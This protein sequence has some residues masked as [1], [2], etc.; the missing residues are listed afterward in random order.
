VTN[1]TA[2]NEAERLAIL[3]SYGIL[4]TPIEKQFDDI[5]ELLSQLLDVPIAAVNLIAEGRQWFKAEVGLGTRE[6]PLDN[7]I[8]KFALLQE[9]QMVVP[10]TR[11]DP[12]FECN[13][14]VVGAPGLR[15]YAGQLL[16]TPA[17]VP[18]GTLCVLD[19]TPRPDGLTSR[20]QFILETLAQQVMTQ[21][22]LRKAIADQHHLLA[23]QQVIQVALKLERDQSQRLLEGM[24]EG[25]IYLDADFYVRQINKGGLELEKRTAA[26]IV[27]KSLWEAW[28]GTESLPMTQHYRHAMT[29]RVPANFE[30]HYVFPDGRSMWLDIRAHP[31]NDGLAIFYRDI[32]SRKKAEE[33]LRQTAAALQQADQRKNEF[34]AMLAHE[35]RNPLAPISSAAMVLSTR[36]ADEATVRR[37]SAVISRQAKH[38]T[39]LIDDL[40]DVSRV[41]QGKVELETAEIDAKDIIADA[42]EQVRPLIEKH[43]HQLFVQLAPS[44]ST[45][46]GDRKRLVQVITNLLGNAAKYT[47]DGGR[48]E[49]LLE[50]HTDM[51]GITVRDNGIGMSP[52]LIGSAFELFSQGKRG[53]DRSQGGLGIGLALVKSLVQLHHGSVTVQS[54]GLGKGSTFEVRIPRNSSMAAAAGLTETDNDKDHIDT[55][56]IAVV[57]DNEDAATTLALLLETFGHEVHTAFTAK[58]ALESLPSFRPDVC[59]LDIGL[60]EIDGFDLARA[61]RSVPAIAGAVLI[62]VTGYGQEKD[63]Q[64]ADAAGFDDLFTKPVDVLALNLALQ[65]VVRRRS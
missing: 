59:L 49:V 5:V 40:L 13:P 57:D 29:T 22:E 9:R 8:C 30:E 62:A 36:R 65:K 24:D 51:I 48:I 43:R 33:V 19:V 63:R 20:E 10:D 37:V 39:S 27:G 26:D 21:I 64:D 7:S 6:M 12:R 50:S 47:P 16:K 58:D 25:F 42:I 17:G 34:L 45:V 56:R 41:T 32:T 28:P 44:H 14:L 1:F 54:G 11:E 4:D 35:L 46:M 52:G 23:Q 55:L 38:M 31:T 60:P 3:D 2:V 53:L 15:F 61:L 18:L